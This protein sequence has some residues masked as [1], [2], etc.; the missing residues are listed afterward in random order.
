MCNASGS[1]H[2]KEQAGCSLHR[3]ARHTSGHLS[4]FQVRLGTAL[5]VW[6]HNPCG[7]TCVILIT[8]LTNAIAF[9]GWNLHVPFC[10]DR[11]ELV[12][13]PALDPAL[14]LQKRI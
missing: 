3:R 4:T 10:A 11:K 12:L 14:P 5:E 2:S 6:K 9:S 13:E 1:H 8:S 7:L